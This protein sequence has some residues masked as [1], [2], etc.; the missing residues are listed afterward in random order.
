[1]LNLKLKLL[2]YLKLLNNLN[3]I[4]Y[5]DNDEVC[6]KKLLWGDILKLEYI[7]DEENNSDKNINDFKRY[8]GQFDSDDSDDIYYSEII[9]FVN[10]NNISE[11]YKYYYCNSEINIIILK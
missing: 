11:I 5:F 10:N 7:C 9:K 3:K 8:L 6:V 1:M 2:N 4:Y